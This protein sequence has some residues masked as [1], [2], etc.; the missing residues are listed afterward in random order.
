MKWVHFQSKWSS[1]FVPLVISPSCG[2]RYL[3]DCCEKVYPWR[4]LASIEYYADIKELSSFI[5]ICIVTYTENSTYYTTPVL[6]FN[7]S[8]SFSGK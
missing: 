2:Y 1:F 6:V 3:V 7:F 4:N 5:W 8:N